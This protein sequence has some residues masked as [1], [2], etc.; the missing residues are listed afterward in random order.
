MRYTRED[1]VQNI[2]DCG[3]ALIDNAE[4]IVTDYKYRCND[5][6]IICTVDKED[7]APHIEVTTQFYAEKFIERFWT[8]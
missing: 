2:K 4:K 5:I 6:K 3:Q 8:E 1:V 7:E